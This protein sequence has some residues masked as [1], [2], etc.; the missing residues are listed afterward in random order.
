[1][2]DRAEFDDDKLDA[3]ESSLVNYSDEAVELSAI[4]KKIGYQKEICNK[5]YLTRFFKTFYLKKRGIE[6]LDAQIEHFTCLE[7]L[8]LTFNKLEEILYLP[9]NLKELHLAGN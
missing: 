4:V 9:P 1:M 2:I 5:K 3:D 6:T 7:I 8:N